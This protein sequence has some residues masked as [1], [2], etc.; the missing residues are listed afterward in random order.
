M[1]DK[2]GNR[3]SGWGVGQTK[4]GRQYLPPTKDY[5]GHGLKVLDKYDGGNNDWLDFNNNPNESSCLS[6]NKFKIC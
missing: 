5:V 3:R 6:Y 4:G 2:R 1:F